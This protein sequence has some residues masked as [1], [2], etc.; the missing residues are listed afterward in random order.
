MKILLLGSGARE[1]A[2]AKKIRESR[3]CEELFISPANAG[4][5]RSI[6]MARSDKTRIR[7]FFIVS[8]FLDFGM[9]LAS[10]C[11]LCPHYNTGRVTKVLQNRT[12]QYFFEKNFL[13]R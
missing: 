3:L 2:I 5:L 6:V 10:F 1:H 8:S 7:N 4:M 12:M 9:R 11:L 13:I